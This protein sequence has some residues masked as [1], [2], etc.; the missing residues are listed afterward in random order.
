MPARLI[1]VIAVLA[2]LAAVAAVEDASPT[3]ARANLV[4]FQRLVNDLSA[5]VDA[6]R[7]PCTDAEAKLT[8][9][10]AALVALDLSDPR[11][12]AV[13]SIMQAIQ[14]AKNA[15][16]ARDLAC[17]RFNEAERQHKEARG[18]LR[19]AML[20]FEGCLQTG[21]AASATCSKSSGIAR[22]QLQARVAMDKK[23]AF[24]AAKD[25]QA[26]VEKLKESAKQAFKLSDKAISK[27]MTAYGA[28]DDHGRQAALMAN[29]TNSF[30]EA[31]RTQRASE[32]VQTLSNQFMSDVLAVGRCPASEPA[33]DALRPE[34]LSR[35][36]ALDAEIRRRAAE[37]EG[38][39]TNVK[40]AAFKVE[41]DSLR[42]ASAEERLAALRFLQL[43]DNNPDVRS[44]FGGEAV[45]F[46]AGKK[47][48]S[49]AIRIDLDRIVDN[50]GKD[51]SLIIT[52]PVGSDSSSAIYSS[53]DG[54][55]SGIK[56]TLA[57]RF[58]PRLFKSDRVL[59][60]LFQFGVQAT[61]GYSAHSYRSPEDIGVGIK[62][63]STP[64]SLGGQLIYANAKSTWLHQLGVDYSAERRFA[65]GVDKTTRCPAVPVGQLSVRCVNAYF[66]SPKDHKGWE[67]NY[68]LRF[69]L[70]EIALAPSLTYESRTRVK[71]L[72]VPVY[73]IGDVE[74]KALS[75][76]VGFG[77]SS[78]GR[79]GIKAK[80]E[81]RVFV[82][83][84]FSLAGE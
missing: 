33:C 20:G 27:S 78:A 46:S 28:V 8:E 14:G 17:D 7:K 30:E 13:K 82:S 61:V 70:G 26:K 56:A 4:G 68:T 50:P 41:A 58:T 23:E 62:S 29:A 42:N 5:A 71:T 49:A 76:G 43:V 79:D 6:S 73:L 52:A 37:S 36:K 22:Q 19:D 83:S 25:M 10:D 66:E 63:H 24:A 3:E 75:A 54:I 21:E 11:P 57:Y 81:I 18:S 39:L 16:E 55:T 34:R 40:L 51:A 53:E 15:K 2:P 32:G 38:A 35:A 72:A 48:S 77:H 65:D 44:L 12:D 84:P 9:A 59:D 31:V 69:K 67:F 1:T 47:G 80:S 60:R 64:W 74:K 45:R